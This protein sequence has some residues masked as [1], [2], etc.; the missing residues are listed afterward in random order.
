MYYDFRQTRQKSVIWTRY[1]TYEQTKAHNSE[2]FN[3]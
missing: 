3:Y 1:P 2:V